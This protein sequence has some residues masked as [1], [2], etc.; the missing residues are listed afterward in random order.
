MARKK[1]DKNKLIILDSD[2]EVQSF[3]DIR[4]QDPDDPYYELFSSTPSVSSSSSTANEEQVHE[5][6]TNESTPSLGSHQQSRN[7]NCKY[8]ITDPLTLDL[9]EELRCENHDM[10]DI[11]NDNDNEEAMEVMELSSKNS[12]SSSSSSDEQELLLNDN[13][14]ECPPSEKI[15]GV[16][17]PSSLN[18]DVSKLIPGT[19]IYAIDINATRDYNAEVIEPGI[20]NGKFQ[21]IC[22][23]LSSIT[24]S[25]S[26][27]IILLDMV[28]IQFVEGPK[29]VIPLCN[30]VSLVSMTGRSKRKRTSRVE[31]A[32]ASDNNP[33]RLKKASTYKKARKGNNNDKANRKQL[34]TR[35][36]RGRKSSLSSLMTTTTGRGSILEN[37]KVFSEKKVLT[38][39]LPI[40]VIVKRTSQPQNF[41]KV[42][43]GKNL[44]I[45]EQELGKV[46]LSHT[47]D[48]ELIIEGTTYHLLL[49]KEKS[50]KLKKHS[51]ENEVCVAYYIGGDDFKSKDDVK[52]RLEAFGNLG[53]LALNP[54]KLCSRLELLVS[55]SCSEYKGVYCMKVDDFELIDEDQHVG[56]LLHS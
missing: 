46:V 55:P 28:H 3:D 21:F 56:K 6:Y 5:K 29:R 13:H 12:S 34:P 50:N 31:K 19:L 2:D 48:K 1:K 38:Y 24:T 17:E 33:S 30:V 7:K 15:S 11:E 8:Q 41:L 9:S 39:D 14:K 43:F 51:F 26:I 42:M 32:P 40:D 52:D 49:S 36:K 25:L 47:L 23:F 20:E 37:A 54:G 18:Y 16:V 45:V 44:K 22:V 27:T 35:K 53:Q 10:S 4:D